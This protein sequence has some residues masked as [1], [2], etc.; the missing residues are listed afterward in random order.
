MFEPPLADEIPCPNCGEVIKK[1]AILCR[2][3][4]LGLSS[5]HFKRCEDCGEMVR[6]ESRVCRFCKATF[7]QRPTIARSISEARAAMNSYGAGVRSQVFEVIV[8]QAM[9]GAPWRQICAGPM[10]VNNIHPD[11]IEAEVNRRRAREP[12]KAPLG[13]RIQPIISLMVEYARHNRRWKRIC[14]PIL[15]ALNIPDS[16]IDQNLDDRPT[17]EFSSANLKKLVILLVAEIAKN[18]NSWHSICL[19]LMEHHGVTNEE[20]EQVLAHSRQGVERP[21]ILGSE[22]SDDEIETIF[23]KMG[24]P[25]QN[26]KISELLE[27][28]Q[29]PVMPDPREEPDSSSRNHGEVYP[30]VLKDICSGTAPLAALSNA[31]SRLLSMLDAE[32]I[33]IWRAGIVL[34]VVTECGSDKK[35]LF[36]A[37]QLPESESTAVMLELVAA[38]AKNLDVITWKEPF[39]DIPLLRSTSQLYSMISFVQSSHILLVPLISGGTTLGLVMIHLSSRLTSL[40]VSDMKR[41]CDLM[42][43]CLEKMELEHVAAKEEELLKLFKFVATR[44][45]TKTLFTELPTVSE[46]LGTFLGFVECSLYSVEGN[47]LVS[48]DGKDIIQIDEKSK[49]PIVTSLLEGKPKL[50]PPFG[51]KLFG[52]DTA[53]V[54]P[55]IKRSKQIGVVIFWKLTGTSEIRPKE[56][57]IAATFADFLAALVESDGNDSA[58]DSTASDA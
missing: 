32:R 39:A 30:L 34:K 16:L 3:C 12:Q 2:F 38:A 46:S 17:Q 6:I 14:L 26:P 44:F 50:I 18:N 29:A 25:P 47:D 56:L 35:N 20:I 10:K 9:A 23:R 55:L 40:K 11:E 45:K 28:R 48:V 53:L 15:L 24:I 33:V 43:I 21:P 13:D 22:I 36:N 54:L 27:S 52:F 1:E 58:C 4:Q 5:E 19:S 37:V 51:T 8:R 57:E 7:E 31:A 41:T 49:D 42:A